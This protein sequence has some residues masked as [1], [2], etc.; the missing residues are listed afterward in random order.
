MCATFPTYFIFLDL[1]TLMI[2]GE[3]YKLWDLSLCASARC[4]I[5]SLRS[6]YSAPHSVPQTPSNYFLS[7]ICSRPLF[8][9]GPNSEWNYSSHFLNL[10]CISIVVCWIF[11]NTFISRRAAGWL[12][13]ILP[14]WYVEHNAISLPLQL[15]SWTVIPLCAYISHAYVM[16][17]RSV[18]ARFT[19][20]NT[21][22]S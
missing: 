21:G 7:L 11:N 19:G 18:A 15:I 12:F 16:V 2:Y 22:R 10:K 1:V 14:R 20:N 9:P 6:K 4:N 8:T 5:L 3:N 17:N 13:L